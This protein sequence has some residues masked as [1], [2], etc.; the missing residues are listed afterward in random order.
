MRLFLYARAAKRGF[1]TQRYS[2]RG[3]IL[4]LYYTPWGICTIT[5]VA[6]MDVIG[7]SNVGKSYRSGDVDLHAVRGVDFA[8]SEVRSRRSSAPRAAERRRC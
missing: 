2:R 3:P 5:E 7:G 4:L 8:S 6:V 1:D